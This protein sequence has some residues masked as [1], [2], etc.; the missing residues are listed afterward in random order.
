MGLQLPLYGYYILASYLTLLPVLGFF[1]RLTRYDTLN[2]FLTV[3]YAVVYW[4]PYSLVRRLY[5]H[6]RYGHRRVVCRNR[7]PAYVKPGFYEYDEA[8]DLF[9]SKYELDETLMEWGWSE[10]MPFVYNTVYNKANDS[11]SFRQDLFPVLQRLA[12]ANGGREP[13]RILD[14]GQGPGNSTVDIL[15]VV[16]NAEVCCIDI[17]EKLIRRAQRVAPEAYF[18]KGSMSDNGFLDA[19]FDLVFNVGGINETNIAESLAECWRVTKPGGFLIVGDENFDA[20][21]YWQKLLCVVGTNL[22][23][24]QSYKWDGRPTRPDKNSRA[25]IDAFLAD[26]GDACRVVGRGG[27]PGVYFAYS[28]HKL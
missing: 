18:F 3:F 9:R 11:N 12:D 8:A 23:F 27:L 2:D 20:S 4:W 1:V 21:T 5:V 19:S 28:F 24:M 22:T 7:A 10:Y 16:A 13:F 25:I 17:A 14:V 6:L 26:K 15:S